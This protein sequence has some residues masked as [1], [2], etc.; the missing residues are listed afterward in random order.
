MRRSTMRATSLGRRRATFRILCSSHRAMTGW[1]KTALMAGGRALDPSMTNNVGLV[2]SSPRSR[3]PTRRRF[4]TVAFSVSPSTTAS[5]CLAPSIPIPGAQTP[6]WS[7]KLAP[8]TMMATRSSPERSAD[9]S[10]ISA[11]SVAATNR[12]DTADFDVQRLFSSM[13]SPHG[14]EAHAVAAGGQL[15]EHSGHGLA[16]RAARRPSPTRRW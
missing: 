7:P 9:M 5:G 1:S 3:S 2:T 16:F 14:L 8:S 6:R 10:S 4:T 13:A 11:D 12:R 15:G